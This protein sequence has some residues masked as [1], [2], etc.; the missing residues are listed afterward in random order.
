MP[1]I[2]CGKGFPDGAA[3]TPIHAS[4]PQNLSRHLVK[5][6]DA[7]LV[8]DDNHTLFDRLKDGTD[9]HYIL[10][11]LAPRCG[12]CACLA[13]CL[14]DLLLTGDSEDARPAQWGDNAF[15]YPISN[16]VA[17]PAPDRIRDTVDQILGRG[18]TI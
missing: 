10:A 17:N 2:R 3:Q 1:C 14:Q 8:V 15:A 9:L 7:A 4:K 13:Q 18:K 6:S 11:L 12:D 16:Y 5:D